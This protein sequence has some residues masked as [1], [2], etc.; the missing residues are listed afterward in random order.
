MKIAA[1]IFNDKFQDDLRRPCAVKSIN[2]RI[3]LI[4]FDL[5]G[6]LASSIEGINA[7]M[8]K[9][10]QLFGYRRPSQDKVRATIG[11]TLEDS[12]RKL[13]KWACPESDIP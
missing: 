6:T 8:G 9:A 4:I 13:T 11:L 10:L 7:C 12:I 5:D 3:K 1:A 2:M